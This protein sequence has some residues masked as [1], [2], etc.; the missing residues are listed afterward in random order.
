MTEKEFWAAAM[1]AAIDFGP[2]VAVGLVAMFILLGVSCIL[3][4]RNE[5]AKILQR[6]REVDLLDRRLSRR[7]RPGRD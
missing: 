1:K 5:A 3:E 6:G 7:R 4:D 2:W